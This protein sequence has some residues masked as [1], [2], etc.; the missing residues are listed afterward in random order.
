MK[1]HLILTSS[2][3]SS[4]QYL[5]FILF[6]VL[7]LD[8]LVTWNNTIKSFVSIDFLLCH[9]NLEKTLVLLCMCPP[10]PASPSQLSI[11]L[12]G[13]ILSNNYILSWNVTNIPGLFMDWLWS[14]NHLFYSIEISFPVPSGSSWDRGSRSASNM[15]LK[16]P[17]ILWLGGTECFLNPMSSFF[18]FWSTSSRN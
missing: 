18:L 17:L 7:P 9:S 10:T 3:P 6:L 11:I 15:T 1:I 12:H 8:T 2:F 13:Q 5:V 16:I 14:F 4:F